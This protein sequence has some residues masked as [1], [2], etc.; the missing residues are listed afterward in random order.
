MFCVVMNSAST[1]RVKLTDGCCWIQRIRRTDPSGVCSPDGSPTLR[2]LHQASVVGHDLVLRQ[3]QV[4]LQGYQ[5][6]E[7]ERDQLPAVH[8]EPFLQFLPG[9]GKKKKPQRMRRH[10]FHNDS[11]ATPA[12]HSARVKLKKREMIHLNEVSLLVCGS[13]EEQEQDSPSITVKNT[14]YTNMSI[15]LGRC[16]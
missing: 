8:S 7:L 4:E 5:D 13:K 10:M 16:E 14:N 2:G 11:S 1:D 15:K 12:S 9:E 6:G 3:V